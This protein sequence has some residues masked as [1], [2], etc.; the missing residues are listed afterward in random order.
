V[1]Q[2]G[3]P[4]LR[5][6]LHR[7]DQ[8]DQVDRPT[9]QALDRLFHLEVRANQPG[10]PALVAPADL[11]SIPPKRSR[12]LARQ[13]QWLSA[14]YFPLVPD[15]GRPNITG[16]DAGVPDRVEQIAS[17]NSSDPGADQRLTSCRNV[18]QRGFGVAV[19]L[20]PGPNRELRGY[21]IKEIV[22]YFLSHD[23]TASTS[24][25]WPITGAE[26]RSF[27]RIDHGLC[28][29]PLCARNCSH[30]GAARC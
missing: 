7:R 2:R 26:Y 9:R 27:C 23:C 8:A 22:A 18:A 1:D 25:N 30:A 11:Q 29:R 6:R 4:G 14:F 24:K 28:C 10:L 13:S 12:L 20:L 21:Q 17:S 16:V 3:R 15:P 5:H 19:S